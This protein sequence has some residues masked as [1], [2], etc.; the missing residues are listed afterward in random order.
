M[1]L[2]H[3]A[4]R[5]IL[6]ALEDLINTDLV[7][8]TTENQDYLGHP[9]DSDYVLLEK[10]NRVGFEVFGEEIRVDFFDDHTHFGHN[11]TFEDAAGSDAFIAEAV[12]LLHR[13]LSETLIKKEIY[14]GR[15]RV[16]YEWFF[17]C[18]DGRKESIG[19]PWFTPLFTFVNPFRRK[20]IQQTHWRF[21]RETGTFVHIRNDT[22]SVH[23]FDWDIMIEI[24]HTNGVY[25]YSIHRYFYDEEMAVFYWV[26]VG[27]PGASLFDTES[28]ALKHAKEAAK[29][30]CAANR[31]RSIS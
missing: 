3:D 31:D 30:Y 10:T 29:S 21:H 17:L 5:Q 23:S 9:T 14:R 4:T 11:Y 16:R 13:L 1:Q 18:P 8:I 6:L 15:T 20:T 19:G 25:A 12:N 7:E 26:P 2:N 27:T 22:V 28:N 24:S